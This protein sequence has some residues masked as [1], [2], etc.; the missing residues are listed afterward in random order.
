[1][2]EANSKVVGP[3]CLDPPLTPSLCPTKSGVVERKR[4]GDPS[5]MPDIE[6]AL[7]VT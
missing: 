4:V 6:W 1:M 2:I 3:R 5:R 7:D